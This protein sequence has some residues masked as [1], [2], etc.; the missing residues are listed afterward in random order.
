MVSTFTQ[1][2]SQK[3]SIRKYQIVAV[4][5]FLNKGDNMEY[6]VIN[7]TCAIR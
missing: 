6:E 7:F 4:E 1:S 5:Y 3:K 2:F